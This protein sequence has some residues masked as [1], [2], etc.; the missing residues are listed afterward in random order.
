MNGE[1]IDGYTNLP[2]P[3]FEIDLSING[4]PL[5]TFKTD[6]NGI[7]IID[8]YKK[9]SLYF[10]ELTT[11]HKYHSLTSYSFTM[12]YYPDRKIKVFLYPT[13]EY[14]NQMASKQESERN[15]HDTCLKDSNMIGRYSE[16][17]ASFPGGTSELFRYISENVSYPN[18]SIELNDQGRVIA[19]FVVECDGTISNIVIE[20]GVSKAIDME[21]KRLIRAMPKWIPG[22]TVSGP[23]R[24]RINLPI[25]FVFR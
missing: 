6:E 13:E 8:N 22:C 5:I 1:L 15:L 4:D 12:K 21:A 10:Y 16:S 9:K 24:A 7:F 17:Q 14:E 18:E 23:A 20:K 2:L 3:F 25:N 19:S 11:D